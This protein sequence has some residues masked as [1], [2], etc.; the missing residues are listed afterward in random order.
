MSG[1]GFE[2]LQG[3]IETLL[4]GGVIVS[5]IALAGG[6]LL[7]FAGIAAAEWVL[8]AGLVALM[9]LPC[10]RIAFSFADA[11]RRGDRLLAFA[12]AMVLCVMAVSL[13]Y[14]LHAR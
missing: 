7:R 11:L 9:A 3:Q 5:A 1:E 6:L 14:S 8:D 13:V 4:G 2:R 12:T 10:A